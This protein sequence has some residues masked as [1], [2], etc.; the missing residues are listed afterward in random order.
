MNGLNVVSERRQSYINLA[1]GIQ[2]LLA[3]HIFT[4]IACKSVG[5]SVR[6]SSIV[7][8]FLLPKTAHTKRWI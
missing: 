5:L 3:V 1:N 4:H 7:W 6:S 2:N 8:K